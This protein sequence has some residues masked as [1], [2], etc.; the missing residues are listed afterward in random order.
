LPIAL[1]RAESVI[2]NLNL[3]QPQNK[4]RTYVRMVLRQHATHELKRLLSHHKS[5]LV[6]PKGSVRDGE[7]V[8]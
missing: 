4:R 6:P 5:I 3:N 2:L 7:I 1:P 8:H